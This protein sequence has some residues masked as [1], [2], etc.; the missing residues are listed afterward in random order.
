MAWKSCKLL[1]FI[2]KVCGE[3]H[4]NL[5]NICFSC[6]ELICTSMKWWIL[7]RFFSQLKFLNSM[8]FQVVEPWNDDMIQGAHTNRFKTAGCDIFMARSRKD[9]SE[10]MCPSR[11]FISLLL[12]CHRQVQF[13]AFFAASHFCYRFSV[14]ICFISRQVTY[15]PSNIG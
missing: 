11:T 6:G 2:S 15:F 1:L 8:T 12:P 10:S 4:L 14:Y 5:Q 7:C 13:L 9:L 3:N